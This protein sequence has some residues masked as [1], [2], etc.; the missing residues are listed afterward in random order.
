MSNH[1]M[2]RPCTALYLGVPG[3]FS[4]LQVGAVHVAHHG[5]P[6][7]GFGLVGGG[8]DVR[9]QAEAL[10]G[11]QDGHHGSVTCPPA[12]NRETPLR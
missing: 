12:G 7:T 9:V 10:P 4:I 6:L 8:G 5:C 11:C 3:G 2:L 1:V